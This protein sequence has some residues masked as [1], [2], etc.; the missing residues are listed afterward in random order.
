MVKE[1]INLHTPNDQKH[2][3]NVSR[4]AHDTCK[5]EQ[6]LLDFKEM[7]IKNEYYNIET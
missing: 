7:Q 6:T 2:S 5:N 4:L 3:K 1:N